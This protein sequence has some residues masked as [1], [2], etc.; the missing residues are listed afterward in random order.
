V[1]ISYF[2]V[3]LLSFTTYFTPK[4]G[5]YPLIP[6]DAFV[7]T[8]PL[9]SPVAH[10]DTPP[11]G[12]F[13]K[14]RKARPCD[15]CR[16][17]KVVCHMP[18]GAPCQRCRSK[19]LACTFMQAPDK[20]K[21]PARSQ[22]PPSNVATDSL[23]TNRPLWLD[24]VSFFSLHTQRT[25]TPLENN[26]SGYHEHLPVETIDASSETL[27]AWRNIDASAH[28]NSNPAQ[29]PPL[30]LSNDDPLD[31][32][33]F[34]LSWDVND[35][36]LPPV[37][38]V[39][40]SESGAGQPS[41]NERSSQHGLSVSYHSSGVSLPTEIITTPPQSQ[42]S[43]QP[44]QSPAFASG[45]P[46]QI[47]PTYEQEPFT[48][49]G[50]L[51][52]LPG[53]FS[54]YIG[55]TGVSDALLLQREPYDADGVTPATVKG[56]QY[57]RVAPPQSETRRESLRESGPVLFGITDHALL[58]KAEPKPDVAASEQAWSTLW[59]IVDPPTA[60]RL[61]QLYMRFVD[62][63]FP[64]VS[65]HHMPADPSELSSTTLP[66]SGSRMSL[67]LLTAMCAAALP[68]VVHDR[69]LYALLLHPPSSDQLYR[70]CWQGVTQELHTPTLSTLQACLLLQQRLPTNLYLHDTA[71]AWSLMATA[72]A[73]AQTM[74]LHRD[75]TGWTAVP[76]WERS[77]RRRLWWTLWSTDTWVALARGMPRHLGRAEDD[78]D[79]DV[80]P[81]KEFDMVAGDTFSW[82]VDL[83]SSSD[84][85]AY[86]LHLVSLTT[87]LADI[88]RSYY[89]LRATRRTSRHLARAMIL[90]RPLHARLQAWR[91]AL[92]DS[93]QFRSRPSRFTI[94]SILPTSQ[95]DEGGASTAGSNGESSIT[96][97]NNMEHPPRYLDGN[98][99]LHLS[100]IVTHMMLFRALLRPLD[101]SGPEER[102]GGDD[103]N[104]PVST[105]SNNG[106]SNS[107]GNGGVDSSADTSGADDGARNR[108]VTRGALLCV[109][110]FV[111][112]VEAL[113]P[114]H[115]NS[116]W[117]GWSRANF[118]MAGSFIVFLL[119]IVTMRR[120]VVT[121]QSGTSVQGSAC[122]RPGFSEQYR[123]LLVWIKRWRWASRVSIHSAAGAK[124]LTN[125]MLLR[126]ETFLGELG[127][128]DEM[129]D[130]YFER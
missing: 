11:H 4:L 119:H 34:D 71:F 110:E 3:L 48:I 29:Q 35:S 53:A 43:Q 45:L 116:F 77:L 89:T 114:T 97:P 108:A 121:G 112:F 67:A 30:P 33:R 74:G 109:R 2:A 124:G 73:V 37:F 75:P 72:V 46:T 102:Q 57:R 24:N 128:L 12:R 55:S 54:F 7:I 49:R 96:G 81:L 17:R 14:S 59:Q 88:Q 8:A 21:R 18:T 22:S 123:E 32:F 56:L 78:E 1:S 47:A 62:P 126:V 25:P 16:R 60:W 70:L 113:N 44:E 69:S 118:A 122:A 5:C 38:N 66:T 64:I 26:G 40:R 99:S 120:K 93:L 90:G 19:T 100:Y 92:P 76:S 91:D 85:S 106:N 95:Q 80:Q 86:L 115:W 9:P 36:P 87:I 103:G 84:K 42:R 105:S 51:E 83:G 23:I 58:E 20:K 27:A 130:P 63:Y 79:T 98:A 28:L 129:K 31:T 117:H 127:G 94:K 13:Y 125:L 65:P 111:E 39:P 52:V 82:P 68:F 101:N 6:M 61:L 107:S 104:S 41:P 15:A 50:S 10:A